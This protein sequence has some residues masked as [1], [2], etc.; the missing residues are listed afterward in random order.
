MK[1]LQEL[2]D[3]LW[4]NFSKNISKICSKPIKGFIHDPKQVSICNIAGGKLKKE[5]SPCQKK[6]Q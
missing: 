6:S 1:T 5:A 2:N 4:D 3:I